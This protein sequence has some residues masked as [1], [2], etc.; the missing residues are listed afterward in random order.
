MKRVLLATFAI[1]WTVFTT[2]FVTTASETTRTAETRGELAVTEGLRYMVAFPQVWAHPTERPQNSPLK[3][4]IASRYDTRVTVYSPATVSTAPKF[5]RQIQ[6]RKG[7]VSQFDVHVDYMNTESE[8]R[9]GLGI[10]V[11]GDLPITVTTVQTWNGNGET[12]GHLPVAAWGTSY[13]TMNFYQDRFGLAPTIYVRPAQ[14]LVIA[15]FDS[16][17][18][19]YYPTYQTEGGADAPSTAAGD[20]TTLVLQNGETFLI[21]GL[22][23]MGLTRDF[24][25]DLSGTKI[26][27]NKPIGVVSGHT[28]VAVM[29]YPDALPPTGQFIAGAHFVR[30]NVHDAM[31]PNY[32][33]GREFVTIPCSYTP[34]RVTGKVSAEFGIDDDRGDVIRVIAL[35]ANTTVRALRKD[36]SELAQKFILRTAGETRIEAAVTDATYWISDKPILMGQYGKSFAKIAPPV[37]VSKGD[38][39][40]G[41]PTVESGMPM[42][43]VVPPVDRWTN[44]TQFYSNHGRDCFLNIVFKMSDI[45]QILIDGKRIETAF[46]RGIQSIQGT[47]YGYIT[48]GIGTGEHLIES[49]DLGIRFAAWNYGSL[50]GLNQGSAY[51]TALGIDWAVPC[52]DTLV[53]TDSVTCGNVVLS[54]TSQSTE[55]GCGGMVAAVPDKVANYKFVVD[56]SF[57][58]LDKSI[59]ASL[60]VIDSSKPATATI[61]MISKSGTYVE[62]TYLFTPD[63]IA[64]VTQFH[65]FG[66]RPDGDSLCITVQVVNPSNHD[67]VVRGVRMR[68]LP[69]VFAARIDAT[70]IPANGS[71]DVRICGVVRDR[72]VYRDTLVV[73]LECSEVLATVINLRSD[74]SATSVNDAEASNS[75]FT[76][77]QGT[78]LGIHNAPAGSTLTL[79]DVQ[80]RVVFQEFSTVGGTVSFTQFSGLARGM[81]LLGVV[82]SNAMQTAT[83]VR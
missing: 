59:S 60:M 3:I 80:G 49:S 70:S 5:L 35:E 4:Q 56:E 75:L 17:V 34:T 6:I 73:M 65:D 15:A 36:G 12:A 52:G 44:Q 7:Q 38:D 29:R 63:T 67:V 18:I 1:L 24:T 83:V 22:I 14:I 33:A 13:Y 42:L 21:K 53:L 25:S 50:D 51:G 19:T 26:E 40:Q 81:Y 61:R 27:S 76:S 82:S 54:C 55:P 9:A 30:N 57:H 79:T 43:Q 71:A 45:D 66:A 2:T 28:K 48:S 77:F 64:A 58:E 16:T 72:N 41:H 46:N 39:S 62:R 23:N 10:E 31:Y 20:S 68:S 11:V 78:A 37:G 47:P 74:S 32:L 69:N 8:T